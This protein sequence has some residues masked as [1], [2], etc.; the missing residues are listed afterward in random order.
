LTRAL[1]AVFPKRRIILARELIERLRSDPLHVIDVGGALGLDPRWA[2]LS[3]SAIR[4]MTFEPDAR[5]YKEM[6]VPRGSNVAL[7]IGLADFAGERTLH[8][9]EAPFASSLYAP[10]EAVLRDF[11]VWPWYQPAGMA[12]VQVDTLD[13]CLSRHRDWRA[14]FVKVDAE[15]ADLDVLN[16][17][18]AALEN[19]FGVQVEVAFAARNIGAPLQGEID[20]WLRHAGFVPH[21]I[22]REHW[23]RTNGVHSALSQPQLMWADAVYFRELAW[24]M[25]RLRTAPSAKL[26]EAR[27]AAML[28]I[29]LVYGRHDYAAEIVAKVRAAAIV[30]T[31]FLDEAD[32]SI[33]QSMIG[34]AHYTL[35]GFLALVM[36]LCVA[37]PLS[38]I[39]SRGQGLARCLI[40]AQ[41]AP[42][43]DA[44][45]R[46]ARRTGLNRSCLPD[47]F[48]IVA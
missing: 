13:S 25:D 27:L 11:G 39:G 22:M 40:A 38:L 36:A 34:L 2:P 45:S 32:R 14:D 48:N 35:R 24:V 33:G 4:L 37:A 26:A 5:S 20:D 44:L 6:V 46:A 31:R 29:L 30:A 1:D 28:A 41:A 21:L 16:G 15:G 47:D 18:R 10:N 3:S 23:V 17:G 12:T 42:L 8:L 43:F 9:T 7:P 19:T